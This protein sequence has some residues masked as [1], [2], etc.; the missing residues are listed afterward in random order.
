[1]KRVHLTGAVLVVIILGGFL[2]WGAARGSHSNNSQQIQLEQISR[3]ANRV[4]SP[5]PKQAYLWNIPPEPKQAKGQ[6]HTHAAVRLF[7][8]GA[9]WPVPRGLGI[10]SRGR[11]L[12]IH[13]HAQDGVV[14]LHR[15]LR[16][17]RF[18]L[19]QIIWLWGLPVSKDSHDLAGQ[20]LRVWKNGKVWREWKNQKLDDK[21]DIIL[22]VGEP[23][24][25]TPLSPFPWNSIPLQD[26][27]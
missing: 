1:M 17:A 4:I 13:T 8:Q 26:I 16:H 22:Q 7:W 3:L 21:D 10:D 11:K 14:H 23:S 20:P 27:S 19:Q 15:P 18:N 2:I 25:Q 24:R 9:A 5:S 12:A 6:Q